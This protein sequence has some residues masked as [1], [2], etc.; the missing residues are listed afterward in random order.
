MTNGD[1]VTFFHAHKWD[2]YAT[3]VE[4]MFYCLSSYSWSARGS[5]FMSVIKFMVHNVSTHPTK[6]VHKATV[7][8]V[9]LHLQDNLWNEERSLCVYL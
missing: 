6:Q 7:L 4:L 1:R 8:L 5:A 9:A 3:D 2:Y